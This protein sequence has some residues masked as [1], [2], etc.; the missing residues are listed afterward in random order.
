MYNILLHYLQ[1]QSFN[2]EMAIIK[3]CMISKAKTLEMYDTLKLWFS[4]QHC[5]LSSPFH[6]YEIR[7]M[8]QLGLSLAADNYRM[9]KFR[10]TRR[11]SIRFKP[12]RDNSGK[13]NYRWWLIEYR[14]KELLKQQWLERHTSV[15][16]R[17]TRKINKSAVY[18][19]NCPKNQVSILK[20]YICPVIIGIK[21]CGFFCFRF[22]FFILCLCFFG[23]GAQVVIQLYKLYIFNINSF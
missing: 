13:V 19:D 21:V 10:E 23:G 16:S 5:P 8:H 4:L 9:E 15:V 12:Y 2:E 18:S 6:V 1:L 17:Y 7:D 3:S 14:A 22:G 20:L 11:C